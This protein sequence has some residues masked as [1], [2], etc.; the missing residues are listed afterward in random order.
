MNGTVS[1]PD[2]GEHNADLLMDIPVELT[3]QLGSC[4][5]RLANLLQLGNGSLVE[6]DNPVSAPIDLLANGKAIARGEIVAIGEQF[7]VHI[8]HVLNR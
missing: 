6:L 4:T 2:P 5:M 8:T 1:G 3:A 7:G